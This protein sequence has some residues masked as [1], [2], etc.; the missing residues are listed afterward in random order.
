MLRWRRKKRE[1]TGCK[2]IAGL[3]TRTKK[4]KISGTIY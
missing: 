4:T 2:L 1:E 3:D